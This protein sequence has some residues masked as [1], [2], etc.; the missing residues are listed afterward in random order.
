MAYFSETLIDTVMCFEKRE[1]LA[2]GRQSTVHAREGAGAHPNQQP[3]NAN[4]RGIQTLPLAL[5]QTPPTDLVVITRDV[6]F[7][8]RVQASIVR[9]RGPPFSLLLFQASEASYACVAPFA[10]SPPNNR[11]FGGWKRPFLVIKAT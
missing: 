6:G 7:R 11:S 4:P 8:D 5:Q 3:S 2:G 10:L 1:F 9:V